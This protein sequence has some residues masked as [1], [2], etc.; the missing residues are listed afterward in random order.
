MNADHP[1]FPYLEWLSGRQPV[2]TLKG[3]T[4]AYL[5]YPVAERMEQRQVRGKLA[6]LHRHYRKPFAERLRLARH[7]LADTVA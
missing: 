2:R 1:I 3:L 4:S 5:A 6:E 7:Q